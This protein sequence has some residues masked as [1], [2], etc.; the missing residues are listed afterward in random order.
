LHTTVVDRAV[1]PYAQAL[2]LFAAVVALAS[3]GVL[4][5]ALVRHFTVPDEE[6]RTLRALGFEARQRLTLGAA[7]GELLGGAAA[8]LAVIGGVA[9]SDLFPIGPA[10]EAEPNPG[11]RVDVL[12]TL[13][14]AAGIVAVA[15][16]AGVF[17]GRARATH[18]VRRSPLADRLARAGASPPAVIGVQSAFR[19]AA[20]TGAT[21]TAV[22]S[23]AIA[24]AT[25]VAALGFGAGLTV[26]L[27]E[28]ARFGWTWDAV[29]DGGDVGIDTDIV[30]ALEESP[31]VTSVVHGISS[32]VTADGQSVSAI[33]FDETDASPAPTILDGERPDRPDEIAFGA[34]TLDRLD[35]SLGDRVD[36]LGESGEHIAATIVGTTLLP[37]NSRGDDYTVGEG[38]LLTRTALEDLGGGVDVA[39]LQLEEG[40]TP[41]IVTRALIADSGFDPF[42]QGSIAGPNR[43]GDLVSYDRVRWVPLALASVLAF[44]GVGVLTHTLVTS[45]RAKRREFAVLRSIGF[46]RGDVVRAS[47]WQGG[48]LAVACLGFGLP[49]GIACGRWIWEAFADSLGVVPFAVTPVLGVVLVGIVTLSLAVAVACASGAVTARRGIA[50]LLRVE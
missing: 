43:T 50:G 20:G 47:A 38:A 39:L 36:L 16:A 18:P 15:V 19:S 42:E 37:L 45:S 4:G 26:L 32:F 6:Q 29:Y 46:R 9:M 23:T 21:L 28:P 35:R 30:A 11:L 34:Q 44:L 10:R 13:V 49:I 7:R 3:L 25:I 24:V 17:A 48:A 5:P 41:D 22:S 27:D 31:L 2:W 8:T 1:A 33:A 40:V 12:P 14:V